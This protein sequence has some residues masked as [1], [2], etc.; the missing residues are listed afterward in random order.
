MAMNGMENGGMKH[1]DYV[2]ST[3]KVGNSDAQGDNN[4]VG[5]GDQLV[6]VMVNVVKLGVCAAGGLVFGFAAEKGKGR[7]EREGAVKW[8]GRGG[9]GDTERNNKSVRVWRRE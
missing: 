5:V 2:K 1:R 9:A 4:E 8:D 7:R 6:H 3:H